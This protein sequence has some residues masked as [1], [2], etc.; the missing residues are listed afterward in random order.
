MTFQDMIKKSVLEGFSGNN[1]NMAQI[2]TVLGITTLLALYIFAIYY[3]SAKKTFYNKSFNISLALITVVTASIILAMQSNLVISLGMV[4]ALSIIRFRT[5]VK[6]PKDLVFLF[7]AISTGIIC[8]AGMFEIAVIAGLVITVGLFALEL[9]P[10]GMASMLLVVNAGS[11]ECE[12]E[13]LKQIGQF[14][15]H[16]S[17]KS[18][19]TSGGKT[20]FIVELKVKEQNELLK[21]VSAVKDVTGVSLIAHDGEVNF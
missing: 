20:D 14:T 5:A 16:Y 11:L 13:V 10:V 1:I 9:T 6:D 12:E 18:R 7:W 17:V 3:I 4:G 21:A 2:V 19:N 8:G 15:R